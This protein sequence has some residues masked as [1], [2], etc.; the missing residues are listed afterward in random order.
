MQVISISYLGIAKPGKLFTIPIMKLNLETTQVIIKYI[1][2]I[3]I[4]IGAKV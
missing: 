2:Q 4:T 3:E 1:K